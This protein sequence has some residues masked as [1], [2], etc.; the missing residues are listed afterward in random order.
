MSFL[1]VSC[2]FVEGVRARQVSSSSLRIFASSVVCED[3][4]DLPDWAGTSRPNIS[5]STA[6]RW[7]ET[8]PGCEID[9][10]WDFQWGNQGVTDPG[11]DFV[12][13]ASGG[14]NTF[15]SYVDGYKYTTI[16]GL[17]DIT[18]IWV[19]EVL[20]PDFIPF[21]HPTGNPYSAEFYCYSDIMDYDNYKQI[22]GPWLE[23]CYFCV[24][25]NVPE[26]DEPP[27]S[28]CE[29]DEDNDGDGLI[30]ELDPG[31]W[32]DDTDQNT[33]DPSRESENQKPVITLT[34][35]TVILSLNDTFD[36]LS[37]Q[38]ALD[39]EDG[40]ISS[41]TVASS[42]VDTATIGTYSVD[43][44]V[45]DS[46]GLA[47]ETKTLI[48]IVENGCVVR[49]QCSDEIDNDEDGF[50]DELDPTCCR[51]TEQGGECEYDPEIDDEENQRPVITLATSTVILSLND[52]FD[53]LSYQTALDYEDGDITSST[54]ASSTVDVT[55]VGTYSVDYDVEDSEGLAAETKTLSVIVESGYVVK[56]QCSDEIDNDEDGFIDS[57]DLTCCRVTEQGGECVYDPEIDDEENQKPVIT[58]TGGN[59]SFT[60]GGSYTEQGATALDNEDGDITDDIVVD[61]SSINPNAV[62]TYTVTYN[63]EDSEGLSA[64]EVTRS[65]SV[66]SGGGGGGGGCTNCGGGFVPQSIVI[67]DEE[68][69]YIGEGKAVVSWK[70]NIP[71]T[72]QV[73]YGDE[74][75]KSPTLPKLYG[76]DSSLEEDKKLKTIHEMTVSELDEETKYWF[77]PLS[78]NS[79]TIP[80]YGI[81]LTYD[82]VVEEY[83]PQTPQCNYLLEYIRFGADNNPV[84]VKKLERFL[85]EFEE[86]N[87]EVNGVYELVDFNAVERFQTKYLEDILSP[88]NHLKPTGYVYITTKKKINEI[89]CEKEFPLTGGQLKE[90]ETYKYN[91][92]GGPVSNIKPQVVSKSQISVDKNEYDVDENEYDVDENEYDIDEDEYDVNDNDYDVDNNDYDIPDDS[93]LIGANTENTEKVSVF[94]KIRSWLSDFFGSDD[95]SALAK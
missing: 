16:S 49:P 75:I 82:L 53:A 24:G 61:S 77:R 57:E 55:T 70:T 54:V 93:L 39:H 13:E 46:E 42:T 78:D 81:E 3:E 18:E 44:D 31:C 79:R 92:I 83:I 84:E 56:P 43:Y 95:N 38:T 32:T 67:F 27:P 73:L 26:E 15:D 11:G 40:D 41:D 48:V 65:V 51:V 52:T 45:E 86:E 88:W 63:V 34:T 58:L 87:L 5:A 25:F 76:Y 47:A 2:V 6:S 10:S 22:E 7:A 69:E 94:A 1:F 33:Y 89:Y 91:G 80:V 14:W 30:D 20:K 28:V 19:R 50:I 64:D 90:I 71:A 74:S 17:T 62:G 12:G 36:A 4:S 35:S 21:T 9:N 72:S 29:D 59:V 66:T 60:A 37:Y 8:H 68:I 85:N 23:S